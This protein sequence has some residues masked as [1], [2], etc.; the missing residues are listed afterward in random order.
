MSQV[1]SFVI[2]GP[3]ASGAATFV[4][5]GQLQAAQAAGAAEL[6]QLTELMGTFAIEC[7]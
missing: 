5:V 7:D 3:R 2:D 6:T 4:D 1:D